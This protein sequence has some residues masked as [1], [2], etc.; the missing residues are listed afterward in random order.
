MLRYDPAARV[1]PKEVRLHKLVQLS[2]GSVLEIWA[3]RFACFEQRIPSLC[4]LRMPRA[5]S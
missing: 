4:V 3:G 2:L 1:L 5:V